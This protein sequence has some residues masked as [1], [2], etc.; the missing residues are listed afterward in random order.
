MGRVPPRDSGQLLALPG[1]ISSSVYR[2]QRH[3]CLL[4]S[5]V[6]MLVTDIGGDILNDVTSNPSNPQRAFIQECRIHRVWWEHLFGG[7]T[8]PLPKAVTKV[9]PEDPLRT[10]LAQ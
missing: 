1:P 6:K 2:H 5:V 10:A 3:H 4:L 9:S 7:I 8:L